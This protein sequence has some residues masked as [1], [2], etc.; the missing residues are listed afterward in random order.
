MGVSGSVGLATTAMTDTTYANDGGRTASEQFKHDD[1]CGLF[2]PHHTIPEEVAEVVEEVSDMDTFDAVAGG[3]NGC[4]AP[5]LDHGVYYVA[6]HGEPDVVYFGYTGEGAA[7]ALIGA[8]VEHGVAYD[9]TG[10]TSKKVA[11][12][13][14]DVY[15]GGDGA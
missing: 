5:L 6:Q 4:T 11:V 7:Y 1:T 9:W 3:C 14:S 10:D 2:N 8:C 15:G 13:A 12:G